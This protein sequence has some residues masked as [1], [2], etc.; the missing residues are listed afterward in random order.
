[1]LVIFRWI[2]NQAHFLLFILLLLSSVTQIFRYHIYQ[3]SIYF[4]QALGAQ[5]Q[6]DAW[7]SDIDLGDMVSVTGEIITSKRGE[8]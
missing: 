3:H 6:L 2:R 1:M 4:G 5:R 8:L 7:K